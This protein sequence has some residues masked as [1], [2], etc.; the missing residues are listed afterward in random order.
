MAPLCKRPQTGICNRYAASGCVISTCKA[1]RDAA[2]NHTQPRKR[3]TATAWRLAWLCPLGGHWSCSKRYGVTSGSSNGC[4]P[5]RG[6]R[7]SHDLQAGSAALRKVMSQ[8]QLLKPTNSPWPWASTPR[9]LDSLTQDL[10]LPGG[11]D[12]RFLGAFRRRT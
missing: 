6:C 2:T 5:L 7:E 9:V 4:L 3:D 1:L 8:R 10:Q 12:E 11:S